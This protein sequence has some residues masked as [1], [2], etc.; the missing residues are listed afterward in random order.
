MPSE[1]VRMTIEDAAEPVLTKAERKA[2]KRAAKNQERREQ[3]LEDVRATGSMTLEIQGVDEELKRKQASMAAHQDKVKKVFTDVRSQGKL[4][5][6]GQ[7]SDGAI[8]T[9][10]LINGIGGQNTNLIARQDFVTLIKSKELADSVSALV[11]A[12]H[13]NNGN[14]V[15]AVFPSAPAPEKKDRVPLDLGNPKA[16]AANIAA[17]AAAAAASKAKAAKRKRDPSPTRA[18]GNDARDVSRGRSHHGSFNKRPRYNEPQGRG[19]NSQQG[20]RQTPAIDRELGSGQ[21]SARSQ[22]PQQQWQFAVPRGDLV[23]SAHNPNR[24]AGKPPGHS[25]HLSLAK[26]Q[27]NVDALNQA[28]IAEKERLDEEID[29]YWVENRDQDGDSERNAARAEAEAQEQADAAETE[30]SAAVE[31]MQLEDEDP[32]RFL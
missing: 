2:A 17:A 19:G 9:V 18:P 4:V 32:G 15:T 10:D 21:G 22:Q 8:L 6:T 1:D 29:G 28:K 27:V 7:A 13:E 30:A 16:N 14:V 24:Q 23:K 5:I 11:T 12:W 20:Q 26:L 25:G 3:K 31:N